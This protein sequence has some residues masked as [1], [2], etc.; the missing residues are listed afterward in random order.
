MPDNSRS[1]TAQADTIV[2]ENGTIADIRKLKR[3][4]RRLLAPE[5]Q[6]QHSE[7]L[8]QNI[9]RHRR[10]RYS[11]NI[12]CYLANDGEIDPTP[13][14]EHAWFAGKNLYLPVLSPLKN[15][16]Y[17]APYNESTRFKNNRFNISEPVCKPA[18][19]I[20]ASQ[21]DLLL[22][23]LVAFDTQGNRIGMGGG[24]YDRTLAYLQHRRYWKK[25]TLLGLAHDIQKA[26][27][28]EAKNWDIPLDGIITEIRSY[29]S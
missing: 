3:R 22:M 7:S 23:P 18:D 9:I 28:L 10:Y 21:L 25:P 29:R 26:E 5:V 20:K 17:F 27:Q 6:Q 2:T 19:W 1:K 4:Q 24:F 16:L 12:A 11:Q 8:C 13:L 15:S 14:I